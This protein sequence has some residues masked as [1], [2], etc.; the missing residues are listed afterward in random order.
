MA[1]AV[2]FVVALALPILIGAALA[3]LGR[4]WWWGALAAIALAFLAAIAPTPEEGESRLALGDVGFLAVLALFVAALTWLGSLL[5][6]RLRS[7]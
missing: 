7:R 5:G 4:P 1:E 3:Y 6:R 2:L